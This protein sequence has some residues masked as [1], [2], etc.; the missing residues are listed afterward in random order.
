MVNTADNGPFSSLCRALGML[1]AERGLAVVLAVAS[2]AIGVVQLAEPIL[3]GRVVDTLSDGGAAFPYIALWALLGLF[4]IMAGAAQPAC[5]SAPSRRHGRGLRAGDDAP[6]RLPPCGQGPLPRDNGRT[7]A[8]DPARHAP[9]KPRR[10]TPDRNAAPRRHKPLPFQPGR[11]LVTVAKQ[12]YEP[13]A[14]RKLSVV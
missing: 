5:S 11:Y 6:G 13:G 12:Q 7:T 8:A 2:L 10:N 9:H 1:T 4:G 3:F 14:G